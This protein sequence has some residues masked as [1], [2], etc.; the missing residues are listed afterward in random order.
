VGGGK[1]PRAE[2]MGYGEGEGDTQKSHELPHWSE[3]CVLLVVCT[4]VVVVVVAAAAAADDTRH[5]SLNQIMMKPNKHYTSSKFGTYD[6]LTMM[7]RDGWMDFLTPREYILKR[8]GRFTKW[9]GGAQ[10]E[11]CS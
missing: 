10:V 4:L 9:R 2:G 3:L 5:L 6:V 11:E 8:V 1:G 7:T